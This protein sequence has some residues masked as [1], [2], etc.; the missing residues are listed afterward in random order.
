M[1]IK[2][3]NF[4]LRNYFQQLLLLTLLVLLVIFLS[5]YS[6]AFFSVRNWIN[7]LNN[8]MAHQL[9][10]AIGMTFVIS[11]GGLDLSIASNLG[12]SGI[13]MALVLKADVPV[14]LSIL[15]GLL[16]ATLL[17]AFNGLL[18]SNFLINPMIIT[19][20]T[21]SVMSGLGLIITRGT[22]IYQMPVAFSRIAKHTVG[23]LPL[24]VIL[25]GAVLVL[26]TILLNWT[27]WGQYTLTMG[28]N[29]RALGRVGVNVKLQKISVYALCGFIAGVA[30]I[31]ITARMNV[32]EA[33]AGAGMEMDAIA[34][35]VM[36]G[37]LLSGGKSTMLGTTI[38]CLLL[39]VMKNG[40]TMM[41]VNAHYQRFI[42]GLILL[43][44]VLV[45]DLQ[46]RNF[47]RSKP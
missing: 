16:S 13:F 4:K 22:P 37:S 40:L 31:I 3:A 18:V 1:K 9:L 10:L 25:A 23:G 24:P 6:D 14:P 36:G 12:L 33:T 42:I 45:T 5:I 47:R 8:H 44:A 32:A 27:K 39:S 19:L 35:V 17:G 11:S 29:E 46:Q 26:G 2:S 21:S 20:G 28:S 34:A 15:L 41:S 43:L 30:S 38:A 7:I